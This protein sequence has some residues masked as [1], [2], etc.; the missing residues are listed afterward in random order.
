MRVYISNEIAKQI[1]YELY[2][3]SDL[4]VGGLFLGYCDNDDIIITHHIGSGISSIHEENSLEFD[5]DYIEN[6]IN[7]LMD[8]SPTP[9]SFLGLWHS[10]KEDNFYFSKQDTI[11]NMK[12]LELINDYLV[13]CIINRTCTNEFEEM[14]YLIEKKGN[15]V[16]TIGKFSK[17]EV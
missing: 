10:H 17:M 11:M 16:N 7:E 8:Y 6:R 2:S 14:V 3:V 13:S 9:L 4:E 5:S 12:Y 15:K 1:H